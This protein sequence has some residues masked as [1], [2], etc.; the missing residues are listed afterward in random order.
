MKNE[1]AIGLEIKSE[2]TL[3]VKMISIE[4]CYE[5]LNKS[6][7]QYTKEQVKQ[8]RESLYLW[9]NIFYEHQIPSNE[10]SNG[11]KGNTL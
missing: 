8:I 6:N 9:V 7:H 2:N 10:E 3:S 5:V 4:K 1:K 11:E